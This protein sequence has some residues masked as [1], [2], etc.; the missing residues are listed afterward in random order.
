[1]GNDG[2]ARLWDLAT[3]T[4]IG[5]PFG[6]G[7]LRQVA[8]SPDGK[9]LAT[10]GNDGKARLWDVTTHTQIGASLTIGPPSNPTLSLNPPF[11]S[12]PAG[13]VDAKGVL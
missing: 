6:D 5:P 7:L 12:G 11:N 4:Q 13:R 8:F 3:H 2:K 9:T 10:V 1:V